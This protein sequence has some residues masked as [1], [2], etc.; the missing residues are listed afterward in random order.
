MFSSSDDDEEVIGKRNSGRMNGLDDEDKVSKVCKSGP[1]LKLSSAVKV[2]LLLLI[3]LMSLIVLAT[4]DNLRY[5]NNYSIYSLD[6]SMRSLT[7]PGSCL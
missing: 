3:K 4:Q 2:G 7:G 6:T 5:Y 1:K